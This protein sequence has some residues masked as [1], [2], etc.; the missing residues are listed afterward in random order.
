MNPRTA[1]RI[2]L[3]ISLFGMA[4]S[5]ALSYRELFKSGLSCPAS[6]TPGAIF[7]YPACVYGLFMYLVIAAIAVLGLLARNRSS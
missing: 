6:G 5:G 4:F 1:L 3:V 7:G 2:I